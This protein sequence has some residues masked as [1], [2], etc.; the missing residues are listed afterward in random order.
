ME[1]R[2]FPINLLS[3]FF[4]GAISQEPARSKQQILL[5]EKAGDLSFLLRPKNRNLADPVAHSGALFILL[6]PVS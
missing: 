6:A 5:L 1:N 3:L 4:L 2:V